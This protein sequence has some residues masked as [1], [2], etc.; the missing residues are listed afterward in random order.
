MWLPAVFG[1][2]TSRAAICL[3]VRPRATRRR[4]STSRAVSPAGPS[5]RRATRWPAAASTASTASA[6]RRPRRTSA[7]SSAAAPPRCAARG[8][9]GARAWL[10]MRQRLRGF[11]PTARSRRRRGRVGSRS[12]RAA[13][14]CCTAIRASGA[15]VTDC[16]SIRSVKYGC[17]RT[18]SHSPA[19]S[20]PGLSQ[21]EFETPRRPKS[22]TSPARYSVSTSPGWRPSWRPAAAASSATAPS[23][24]PC[25]AISGRRS[26]AIAGARHRTPRR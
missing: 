18:R 3:L 11:A 17:S 5:R 8:T 7:R 25:R 13:P 16:W 1:E 6:S 19:P 14:G 24:Q 23:A 15:S 22:W 20:G 10:G 21:I 12:R 9:A 2:I 4:I 26:R